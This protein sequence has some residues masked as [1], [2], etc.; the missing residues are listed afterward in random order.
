MENKLKSETIENG[1]C[2]AEYQSLLGKIT[3]I[4]LC[5]RPN[6]CF[7]VSFFSTY[8]KSASCE[9]YN[10]LLRVLQYLKT[11]TDAYLYFRKD[12]VK[13]SRLEGYADS[14]FANDFND[15]KSVSGYTVSKFLI[16]LFLS[17]LENKTLLLS[18]QQKQRF[19]H[20]S[21][22]KENV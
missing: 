4:M 8:Q 11:T 15:R 18:L 20:F 9:H 22:F 6:I 14:D 5:S 17:Y 12:S 16:I 13:S 10:Y 2:T 21:P 3:Y 7:S 19:M 1:E